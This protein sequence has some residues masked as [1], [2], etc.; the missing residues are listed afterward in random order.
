MVELGYHKKKAA[1]FAQHKIQQGNAGCLM[2]WRAH[3]RRQQ[4]N[5]M[6][7]SFFGVLSRSFVSAMAIIVA[8]VIIT[9]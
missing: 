8:P 5:T 9:N 2:V 7:L 3:P 1:A 4:A 6:V